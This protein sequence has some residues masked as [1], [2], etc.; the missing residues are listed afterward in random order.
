MKGKLRILIVLLL[1]SL[2][3]NAQHQF[4]QWCFGYGGGLDFTSGKPKPFKCELSAAEGSSSIAD[5]VT[6]KL[7]F[8]TDGRTVYNS[9]HQMMLNGSDLPADASS[10]QAALIVKAPA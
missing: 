4:D 3:T 9:K 2:G 6:G 5:P 7:L 1:S 8:Y 10:S